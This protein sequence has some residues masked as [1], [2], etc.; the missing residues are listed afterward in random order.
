[1]NHAF[2]RIQRQRWLVKAPSQEAAFA[3]R[4][5]LRS[6]LD[7]GL[8]PAFGRAFDEF[9]A[10][11]EVVHIPRLTLNLKLQAG[12]DFIA[13]LAQELR[14]RLGEVLREAILVHPEQAGV[15]RCT[16]PVTRRQTLLHYLATGRVEWHALAGEMEHFV[17]ALR[18][19]ASA[20]ADEMKARSS[21]INGSL[22]QRAATAF[23]LLQL[24]PS[25]A[26]TTLMTHAPLHSVSELPERLPATAPLA[27]ALLPAILHRLI[28]SGA[29][30]SHLLLRMQ[31]MLLA[32]RGND[33]RHPLESCI[34][35]LL[36]ACLEQ[37]T[38]HDAG[39]AALRAAL[40]MLTGPV[41][42]AAVPGKESPSHGAARTGI[43][44]RDIAMPV[45]HPANQALE[46][47]EGLLSLDAGLVLLHP[48]LQRLFNVAGIT[49]AGTHELA[50]SALPRAAALLHWLLSGREEVFEF[51]LTTI[52][53]LLGLSPGQSLPVSTGLL[54]D[55]DRA[56]AGNLLAAAISHWSALGKTSVDGLRMSFLQ[57]RGLLRDI[58]HAWQLQVEPGPFDMLLG[59]LPWGISIVRLPWMTKPIFT[60]WPTS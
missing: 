52:K 3:M 22:S 59:S 31:A 15:R 14:V 58:G 5:Q 11:D 6:Q 2:H 48:F 55:E 27:A 4:R 21:A 40:L 28:A 10:G 16:S 60:E 34:V 36:L 54:S 45:V 26:R 57:R 47:N 35:E 46:I 38:L 41:P 44:A 53:A 12:E 8:L 50:Q 56:E 30:G 42:G 39:T 43:A 13:V 49:P 24:L 18:S 37:A 32:L 33:L 17:Q 20:F 9:H 51:E 7:T 1:M 23:R 19:E 29:L 25:G